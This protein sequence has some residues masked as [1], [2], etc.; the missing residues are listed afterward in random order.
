MSYGFKQG[1]L[2]G[3]WSPSMILDDN[4]SLSQIDWK[5]MTVQ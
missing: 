5:V 3:Y 4:L 1:K 2:I